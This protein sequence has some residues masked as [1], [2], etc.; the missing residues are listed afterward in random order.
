M[1]QH[2]LQNSV[3]ESPSQT[4]T[5][6]NLISSIQSSNKQLSD[7]DALKGGILLL[8]RRNGGRMKFKRIP[9]CYRNTFYKVIDA[10]KKYGCSLENLHEGIG[11]GKIYER[12]EKGENVRMIYQ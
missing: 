9:I 12:E 5:E 11:K 6:P 8:L 4:I 3:T 7:F 10:G 2:C 1:R